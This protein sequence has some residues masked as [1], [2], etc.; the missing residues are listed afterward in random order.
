MVFDLHNDL[1]TSTLSPARIVRAQCAAADI[2]VYAVWTSELSRPMEFI[3]KC[4][5]YPAGKHFPFAVED[6]GF[7]REDEVEEICALRPLYCG[8]THNGR[9]RLAGGALSF[10]SL[11]PLGARVAKRLNRAGIAVDAAHL[12]RESFFAVADCTVKLIDSHTGLE[13]VCSHPR[14]L[15][16]E[17]VRIVLDHGGVVGLTAVRDFIG[18]HR[19]EDYVRLIDSFVQRYGVDGACIGTDFYGTDALTGLH[20]YKDFAA[21]ADKLSDLGYTEREIDKIF[22]QNAQNYFSYRSKENI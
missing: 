1:F 2:A 19:A 11:T 13:S 14:N 9:N 3:R 20:S 18:G 8:L 7:A 17:Q 15:T 6:L 5:R 4:L 12:N 10:G 21:I 22:Y 16:D